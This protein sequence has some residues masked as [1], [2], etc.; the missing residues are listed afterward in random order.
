MPAVC[1]T[2]RKHNLSKTEKSTKFLLIN[3]KAN[4]N[5]HKR[6]FVCDDE[7]SNE[8]TEINYLN[9]SATQSIKRTDGE[10]D[11]VIACR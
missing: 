9:L 1:N 3:T 2:K 4:A 8:K 6:R 7:T 5:N 10:S 11:D